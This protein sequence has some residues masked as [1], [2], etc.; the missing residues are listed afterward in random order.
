MS[1][2]WEKVAFPEQAELQPFG[3]I[4]GAISVSPGTFHGCWGL[5]RRGKGL[6]DFGVLLVGAW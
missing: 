3:S 5:R 1:L 4:P 2:V 6:G